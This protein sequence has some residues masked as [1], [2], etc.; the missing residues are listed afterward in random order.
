MFSMRSFVYYISK[1]PLGK[2]K[3]IQMTITGRCSPWN[4][5]LALILVPRTSVAGFSKL[6]RGWGCPKFK[7]RFTLLIL[8]SLLILLRRSENFLELFRNFTHLFS[9]NIDSRWDLQLSDVYKSST[10]PNTN[11]SNNLIGLQTT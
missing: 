6:N 3:P 9:L 10:T 4:M 8:Y 2:S 11:V 7:E 1:F 5:K